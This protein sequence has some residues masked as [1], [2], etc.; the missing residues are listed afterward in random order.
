MKQ[1]VLEGKKNCV[2]WRSRSWSSG[3]IAGAARE[4]RHVF[5]VEF[6]IEPEIRHVLTLGAD[7]RLQSAFVQATAGNNRYAEQEQEVRIDVR[8]VC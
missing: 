7:A 5:A 6:D 8:R 1:S 3:Q 2:S 4:F